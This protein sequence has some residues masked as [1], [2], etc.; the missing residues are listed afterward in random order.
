MKYPQKKF[1]KNI[2]SWYCQ[3][4]THKVAKIQ[5]L[6]TKIPYTKSW[7]IWGVENEVLA[8]KTEEKS[9]ILQMKHSTKI[10][11]QNMASWY[12][13]ISTHTVAKIQLSGTKNSLY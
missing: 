7:R 5:L 4:S 9:K 12:R 2:A 3:I 8:R 13:Q 6:G 1:L 11:L 10:F